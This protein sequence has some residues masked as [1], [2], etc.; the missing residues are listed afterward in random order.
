MRRLLAILLA[1][2]A[3]CGVSNAQGVKKR[4]A[5]L[6]FEYGTVQ[7]NAWAIFGTRQDVGKGVADMLVDRLVSDGRYSV[8]ERKAI[9]KILAEQ[10]LSNSDRAD[11][12]SAAKLGKIL[13]VD[14]IVMGSITQFGRDDQNRSV[15]G[16]A[17]GGMASRYGLGGVGHKK[18]K[19]V[20]GL[21]VRLVSTDTAE[22]L[23]VASGKGESTRSGLNLLGAGGGGGS[24]GGGATDMSSSNFADT[25]LGEATE[26]AVTQVA[27]RLEQGAGQLPNHAVVVSGLVADVTGKT[28][29]INVGSKAGVKV[30]DHLAL[31]RTGREITDPVTGKVIRRVEESVGDFTVTEVDELSAVG[32]YT[33]AGTPKVGDTV[34]TP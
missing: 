22:I 8:I 25:I 5:V 4:I 6:D 7:E 3:V 13:G 26:Q 14:A 12:N 10:N 11:P 9:A 15:G 30:G 31:R 17:F 34:K 27:S 19:A 20:V 24:G 21:N 1:S 2:V 33:G 28:L 23:S 32:T 29:V 18:A 16:T